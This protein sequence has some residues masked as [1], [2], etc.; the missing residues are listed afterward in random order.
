MDFIFYEDFIMVKTEKTKNLEIKKPNLQKNCKSETE[1]LGIVEISKR[2]PL[3][4]APDCVMETLFQKA[5][6]LET[7]IK[8]H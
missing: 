4:K 2:E 5:K 6:E 8:Y 1:M 3:S 7:E